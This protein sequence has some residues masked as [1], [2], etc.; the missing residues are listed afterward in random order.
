MLDPRS[1]AALA[2][3]LEIRQRKWKLAVC[4]SLSRVLANAGYFGM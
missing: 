4:A 1:G 2:A 3:V